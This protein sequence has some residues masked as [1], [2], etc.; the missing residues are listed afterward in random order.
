MRI[1]V[2]ANVAIAA[3][4]LIVTI[5]VVGSAGFAWT[6]APLCFAAGYFLADFLSGVVHWCVDTWFDEISSRPSDCYRARAPHS[7]TGYTRL[8]LPRARGA[9]IDDRH[10]GCRSTR[11]SDCGVAAVRTDLLP[12]DRLGDRIDFHGVRHDLSQSEP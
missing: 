8:Q 10:D 1:I 7:P 12:H 3:Y 11:A 4:C 9:R 6:S 5:S 2:G